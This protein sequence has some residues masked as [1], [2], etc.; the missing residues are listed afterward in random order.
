M[1]E[2][3]RRHPTQRRRASTAGPHATWKATAS[4]R[5]RRTSGSTPTNADTCNRQSPAAKRRRSAHPSVCISVHLWLKSFLAAHPKPTRNARQDPIHQTQRTSPHSATPRD[6]SHQPIHY[7][8]TRALRQNRPTAPV[9]RP[10]ARLSRQPRRNLA[11][12][13]LRQTR[14]HPTPAPAPLLRR[15]PRLHQLRLHRRAG[16]AQ[17]LPSRHWSPG[18]SP[19]TTPSSCYAMPDRPRPATTAA[20]PSKPTSIGPSPPGSGTAAAPA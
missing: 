1:P 12:R 14:D 13:A 20:S 19:T 17:C 5:R 10:A 3:H 4:A 11:Q 16:R 7:P 8:A 9:A 18:S 6:P 15:H 2:N